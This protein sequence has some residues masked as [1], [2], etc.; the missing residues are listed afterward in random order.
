MREIEG[1]E[2]IEWYW[3]RDIPPGCPTSGPRKG[4]TVAM[5]YIIMGKL[6]NELKC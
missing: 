1:V 6:L 5:T 2:P 3:P 4:E